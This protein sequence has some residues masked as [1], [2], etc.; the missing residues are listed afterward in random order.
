MVTVTDTN[1]CNSFLSAIITEPDLLV[2]SFTK[3]DVKCFDGNDGS[4][5]LTV[6]GGTGPGTY[7]YLWNNNSTTEDLNNISAGIYSITIADANNCIANNSIF[8][9]QPAQSM[10]AVTEITHVN[11]F[12]GNDGNINLT[13]TGGTPNYTYIWNNGQISEDISSLVAGHYEVTVKDVNSCTIIQSTQIIQPEQI[14]PSIVI[15]NVKCKGGNDGSIDLSVSGGVLP[16]SYLW[17]YG[18]NTEDINTLVAG[19][20]LVTITDAHNCF[21]IN[22]GTVSEPNSPLFLQIS[23]NNVLCNGDSNGSSI[24]LANGGTPNYTYEWSN[25]ITLNSINNLSAG[26]Y[27]VTVTDANLCSSNTH[28]SI[29]EPPALVSKLTNTD[30]LCYGVHDADVNLTVTGG[31]VPYIYQ[32]SPGQISQDLYNVGA[33]VYSVTVTDAHL[34]KSIIST[35]I[36]QPDE[37]I[38]S[39]NIIQT[40]CFGYSDGAINLI[41]EGG[42]PEYNYVWNYGFNTEDISNLNSG[43]YVV[44]VTDANQ[45]IEIYSANV[46]SPP[47]IEIDYSLNNVSCYGNTDGNVILNI[48]GGTIPYVYNWSNGS[49]ARDQFNLPSGPYSFTLTDA[50]NCFHTLEVEINE[51]DSLSA[52]VIASMSASYN[53][54]C[55]GYATLGSSGGTP[56]YTY[57][58]SNGMTG[59]TQTALCAGMYIINI[60]DSKGCS[61]LLYHEVQKLPPTP[62]ASFEQSENGCPP[63]LVSFTNHSL[64]ANSYIWDFGDGS[65]DTT[66]NP[67]HIYDFPGVYIVKLTAIGAVDEDI[68]YST[69]TVYQKPSAFFNVQPQ[70]VTVNEKP[71]HCYNLSLNGYTYLWQ[72]GDSLVSSD[73]EP[74]H[75][76]SEEGI[77]DITLEVWSDK[78]CYDSITIIEAVTVVSECEMIF[79]DAFIPNVSGPIGGNWLNEDF[80][81][82]RI[83][84]PVYRKID[85]YILE[86]FNRWGELIFV[87]NNPDIGWDGYFNGKL[88]QQDVYV[89]KA[90]WKCQDGKEYLKIGDLTL[91]H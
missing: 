62:V 85:E 53:G 75:F 67:T 58:W 7:S 39:S 89:F 91:Y 69:I 29:S 63:L 17:N 34:C 54:D 42:V 70:V 81:S 33:G 3:S 20:Y 43:N 25:G 4:I 59:A 44:S 71:I 15:S 51:P 64:F 68:T 46:I 11:C 1:G 80:Y 74:T 5:N 23:G 36:S 65:T 26:P 86:I 13:V 82:N 40:S 83:F 50:Q 48:S 16:Y 14:S 2:S 38:L 77:Y 55:D 8:I 9:D 41:V 31:T 35:T 45:C 37:I 24:V 61:F 52:S 84:H 32:W 56:P 60:T 18:Q 27:S 88:C 57:Q 66:A 49:N 10:F 72:F 22:G 73:P 78:G 76:Y 90:R 19:N 87:S 6:S 21:S 28:I 47:K 12:G 30:V 79:P